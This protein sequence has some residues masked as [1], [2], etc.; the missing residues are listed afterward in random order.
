[1][2]RDLRFQ[3]ENLDEKFI[4]KICKNMVQYIKD[5]QVL[6]TYRYQ[7]EF[8]DKDLTMEIIDGAKKNLKRTRDLFLFAYRKV[9]LFKYPPRLE[10]EYNPKSFDKNKK[11]GKSK[12]DDVMNQT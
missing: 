7:C 10:K 6:D 3:L 1:M 8:Y 4:K 12:K 5:L 11:K 2:S 9:D